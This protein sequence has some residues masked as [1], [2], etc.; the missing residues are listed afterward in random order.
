MT[1]SDRPLE[2]RVVLVTGAARGI[3]MAIAAG[4]HSAGAT[5]VSI[6][7]SAAESSTPWEHHVVDVTDRSAIA[8]VVRDAARAHGGLDAVVN[9]AAISRKARFEDLDDDDWDAVHA[10]NLRAPAALIRAA[11]SVLR[12]GASIVNISSI[13]GGR[14]FA[15]DAAYSAAKGGLEALT[16]ALAVELAPRGIRVNSIAPG[17]IETPLNTA[18]LSDEAHRRRVEAMIPLGRL[19]TAADVAS[20]AVFLVGSSSSFITGSVIPVDGGQAAAG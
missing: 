11:L 12:D 15:D 5:V 16:R 13:R 2:N 9:N 7:R 18:S 20:A 10:V 17:A 19:G 1:A 6:D 8:A 3:G 4:C 14:G